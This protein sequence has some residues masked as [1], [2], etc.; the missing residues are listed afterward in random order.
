MILLSIWTCP[1]ESHARHPSGY[2]L[3]ELLVVVA[4]IGILSSAAIYTL[5]GTTLETKYFVSN[6]RG[7]I[8]NAQ[9]EAIKRNA[10]VYMDFDFDR[11]G[12]LDNGFTIWVDV[13]GNGTYS[14]GDGDSILTQTIFRNR[15]S[16]G[17]DGPEIYSNDSVDVGPQD[18]NVGGPGTKTIGDG[19]SVVG[20]RF[21][22]N[23]DATGL[24]GTLYIYHPQTVG[25]SQG[26]S[27]GP[28][29]IIVNSMG[30]VRIA[31]WNAGKNVWEPDTD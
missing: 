1:V 3:V 30:R 5:T 14:T 20:H 8:Q 2:T 21:K 4:I 23:P 28:Y 11:D 22:F 13:N 31:T 17:S 16:S 7:T 12:T 15:L 29:A 10:A 6:L 27:A 25:A 9:W 24:A 18:S 26:I 19:L